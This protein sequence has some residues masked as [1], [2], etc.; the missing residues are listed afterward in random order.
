LRYFN[1]IGVWGWLWNTRVARRQA[2]SDS[3]IL[4]FDRYIVPWLSGL[5]SLLAPPIGQSLLVVGRKDNR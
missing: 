5:E 4:V 1:F 2:Q 3:Q